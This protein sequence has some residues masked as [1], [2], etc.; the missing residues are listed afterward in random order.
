MTLIRLLKPF[1]PQMHLIQ[2]F[3]FVTPLVRSAVL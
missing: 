3:D 2:E 1:L